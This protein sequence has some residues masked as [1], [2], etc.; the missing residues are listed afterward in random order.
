MP[1]S[2]PD[3]LHGPSSPE[4][5]L[6]FC[7][8]SIV[9]RRTAPAVWLAI[10]V[11]NLIG[12]FSTPRPLPKTK[13]LHNRGQSATDRAENQAEK[14]REERSCPQWLLK[15][16]RKKGAEHERKR[17]R[18][19]RNTSQKPL[20]V[21]ARLRPHGLMR[22]HLGSLLQSVPSSSPKRALA[23]ERV[24][25]AAPPFSFPSS[26]ASP[27]APAGAAENLRHLPRKPDRRT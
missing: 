15:R 12:G 3:P 16:P 13:L 4:E 7:A 20:K 1:G 25:G 21:P 17:S 27:A 26:S 2:R 9:A 18:K 23:A 11:P 19:N 6:S 5:F 22:A 10:K 24:A 14:G 8:S